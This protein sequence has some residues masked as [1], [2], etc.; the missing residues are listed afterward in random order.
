[1]SD[2]AAEK[3]EFNKHFFHR[4]RFGKVKLNVNLSAEEASLIEEAAGKVPLMLYIHRALNKQA[5]HDVREARKNLA[6]PPPQ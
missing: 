3:P 6:A 2:E 4:D 5:T 1:M